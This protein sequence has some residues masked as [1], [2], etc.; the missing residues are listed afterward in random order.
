MGGCG[1]QS[2]QR[3]TAFINIGGTLHVILSRKDMLT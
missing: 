2:A 1:G 3:R